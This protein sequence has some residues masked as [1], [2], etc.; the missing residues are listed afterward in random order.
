MLAFAGICTLY[1]EL[2]CV[3]ECLVCAMPVA[4]AGAGIAILVLSLACVVE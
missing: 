2:V 1:L 3:V 4:A